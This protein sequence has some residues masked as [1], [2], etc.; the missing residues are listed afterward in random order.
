MHHLQAEKLSLET[1]NSRQRKVAE[2]FPHSGSFFDPETVAY[3]AITLEP[4]WMQMLVDNLP[5]AS[6]ISVTSCHHI[7]INANVKKNEDGTA[8]RY[9]SASC[10]DSRTLIFSWPVVHSAFF[11]DLQPACLYMSQPAANT[12]IGLAIHSHSALISHSN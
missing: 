12:D 11:P 6:R 1:Q 4:T 2:M 10:P 9:D 8:R 3:D 5:W 7:L